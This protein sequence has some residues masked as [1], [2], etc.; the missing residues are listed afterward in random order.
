MG[1]TRKMDPE[2]INK[3]LEFVD[4]FWETSKRKPS[5]REIGG[6]V[7]ICIFRRVRPTCTDF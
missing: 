6:Y 5:N 4:G 2:K 3:I 7:G 1:S